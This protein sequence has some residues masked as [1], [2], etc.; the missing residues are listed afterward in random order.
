MRDLTSQR[1]QLQTLDRVEDTPALCNDGAGP[2][3]GAKG[4]SVFLAAVTQVDSR[5]GGERS[6]TC[7]IGRWATIWV[8]CNLYDKKLEKVDEINRFFEE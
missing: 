8:A 7:L 5:T 2:S 4:S 1:K 6:T 3:P